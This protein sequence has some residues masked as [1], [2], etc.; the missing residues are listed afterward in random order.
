M[1]DSRVE[2]ARTST[3]I[4]IGTSG[5]VIFNEMRKERI[6]IQIFDRARRLLLTVFLNAKRNL[7]L[8]CR[9][10]IPTQGELTNTWLALS[11]HYLLNEH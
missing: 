3:L 10:S 1:Y 2:Q 4:L 9:L 6:S 5:S 7:S 11:M 8:R